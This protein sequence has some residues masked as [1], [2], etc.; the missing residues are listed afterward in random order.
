LRTEKTGRG[1]PREAL[2]GGGVLFVYIHPQNFH[3]KSDAGKNT[4]K[5]T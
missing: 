5:N 1:T 2:R 4:F 3:K